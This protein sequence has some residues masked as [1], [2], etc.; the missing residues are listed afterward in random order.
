[1]ANGGTEGDKRL[2]SKRGLEIL[3]DVVITN[4]DRIAMHEI[5]WGYG[6]MIGEMEGKD[7]SH[8][9]LLWSNIMQYSL[10]YKRTYFQ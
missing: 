4:I 5:T 8:D 1:M 7:V 10:T 2:M 3:D 6:V 9:L